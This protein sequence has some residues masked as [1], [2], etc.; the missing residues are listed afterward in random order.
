MHRFTGEYNAARQFHFMTALRTV[1]L[2]WSLERESNEVAVTAG[3]IHHEPL[4]TMFY[5]GSTLRQAHS[6][7]CK[8]S[9][10]NIC[11]FAHLQNCTFANMHIFIEKKHTYTYTS[12]FISCRV[13]RDKSA[14]QTRLSTQKKQIKKSPYR[15]H[16][17][18]NVVARKRPGRN[19][20]E[21]NRS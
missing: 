16:N 2:G 8:F 9:D 6:D 20:S 15:Y 11:T 17:I 7:I 18:Y 4:W 14:R 21:F 13:S 3:T 19:D 1:A 12:R 5:Y 10:L